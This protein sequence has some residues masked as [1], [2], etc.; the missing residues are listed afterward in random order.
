MNKGGDLNVVKD[1]IWN[2]PVLRD[3]LFV[4]ANWSTQSF[5][6]WEEE[7][8]DHFFN[9]MV[10]HKALANGAVFAANINDT[11]SEGTLSTVARGVA[12]SLPAFWDQEKQLLVYEIGP[13]LLNK[14]SYKDIAVVLGVLHGYND[15]GLYSFSNDQVLA[16]AYQIATSFLTVYPIANVTAD[17]SGGVLGIPI[18]LVFF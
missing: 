14:S 5:D 6:L 7:S 3:L 13:V 18:G 9:R 4:A 12:E 2:G 17:M 10:Y 16:T 15:D 11:D 8:A 1:Q